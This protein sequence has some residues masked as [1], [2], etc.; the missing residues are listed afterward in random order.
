MIT[1]VPAKQS[2]ASLIFESWGRRAQNFARLTARVF[3]DVA[4]A[5][6]YLMHVF[7]DPGSVAFHIVEPTGRTVGFVKAIRSEHRV[8]VGYVVDSAFTGR[9][10][11]TQAVREAVAI[12]EQSAGVSRLWAT[13]ALD[14]PA[15]IRVLEKC[16][17]E[18]E[19][20]LKNW[21]TYPSL[22]GR[23]CDNYSYVRLPA[24]A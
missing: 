22:A 6:R 14:N 9:G 13:C 12:V 3:V 11:A 19:G 21:V 10:I 8:Q 4:D 7:L 1:L 23:A 17:F 18:R 15:S 24:G 20:V 16:G 5:Q 2:D